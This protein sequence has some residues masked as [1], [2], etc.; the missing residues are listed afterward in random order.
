[1]KCYDDSSGCAHYRMLVEGEW[2]ESSTGGRDE[3]TN[4]ATEE[5]V[6]T[7]A[8]GTVEDCE[9]ALVAARKAFDGGEWSRASGIERARV[10]REAA[11]LV[12]EHASDLAAVET[13]EQ[14][15]LLGDQE[16]EV[17]TLSDM[18]NYNAGLASDRQGQPLTLQDGMA[19]GVVRE[20][21]GVVAA[22]T[23][24]NYPMST[25]MMKIAPALA[26]GNS[27]VCKPA[28]IT[29]LTTL[30][31]AAILEEAGVPSGT[32]QVVT[33]PGAE[34][35]RY[36]ASSPLVDMVS[37]TGS[38]EVGIE[39][40]SAG[41]QTI[42]KIVLELGGKCPNIVF[43]DCNM[44]AAL[45]GS[46]LAAFTNAGQVCTSGSRILVERTIHDEFVEELALRADAL[47]VGP[48]S[49]PTSQMGPLVSQ[50]QLE[51]VERY[52][53]SGI[54]EGANLVCGGHRLDRPGYFFEPTVF[55][56]VIPSMTI[57]REEIFGPVL[58]VIPFD[59]EEEAIALANDSDYGLAAGLWTVNLGRAMRVSSRLAAGIVWTN[60]WFA[61]PESS[62]GGGWK[63]SG[64]GVEGGVLGF[65][66][67]TVVKHVAM[68]MSEEPCGL[69]P[70]SGQ[71]A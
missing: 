67:Y 58:S 44:E 62:A 26:A 7:F 19:S 24:W 48:G 41:A 30:M 25:A 50:Q 53:A 15:N 6:A 56:A 8:R 1:M 52:V 43:A 11:V 3:V 32:L 51:T 65:E 71:K 31:L 55:S 61:S 22:I 33:G 23:P 2:I 69:Y 54:S 16:A 49:D 5:T 57:A 47:R 34:I 36:L 12:A 21:I 63:R 13:L 4:P 42:K 70:G 20:P 18:L 38:V 17:G 27:V 45:Q 14:G 68:N 64:L 35:G 60:T 59:S 28:T 46:L 66:E 9:R 39:I 37:L 29:P 10:L 40:A